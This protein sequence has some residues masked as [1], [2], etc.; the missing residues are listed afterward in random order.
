MILKT[1]DRENLPD[2]TPASEDLEI[3]TNP[4]IWEEIINAIK[5]SAQKEQ[6]QELFKMNPELAADT[7][8]SLFVDIWEKE[9]LPKDWTLGTIVGIPNKENLA[10]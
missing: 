2:I 1:P 8:P 9:K 4:P 3:S 10:D 7:L 5:F 6:N